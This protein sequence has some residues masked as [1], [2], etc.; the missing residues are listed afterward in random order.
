MPVSTTI[1][2]TRPLVLSSC[3]ALLPSRRSAGHPTTQAWRT[4]PT[5]RTICLAA[6]SLTQS[7]RTSSPASLTR[8]RT[9]AA[10][11][12]CPTIITNINSRRQARN[13]FQHRPVPH[14]HITLS[15]RQLRQ[16]RRWISISFDS[17]CTSRSSRIWAG[18]NIPTPKPAPCL[19]I[20]KSW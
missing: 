9:A 6:L 3:R 7:V 4:L 10:S 5:H 15:R 11:S 13:N 2:T 17:S 20:S 14:I 8:R 1:T 16:H 19:Q 18:C 12:R